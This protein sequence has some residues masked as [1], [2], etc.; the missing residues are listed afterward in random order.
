[1]DKNYLKYSLILM[2]QYCSINDF[3]VHQWN[4][5]E[6][7][8]EFIKY[9]PKN[10]DYYK[11]HRFIKISRGFYPQFK[12]GYLWGRYEDVEFYKRLGWIQNENGDW[13]EIEKAF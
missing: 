7:P 8:N 9:P 4:R 3:E 10:I 12:K 11:G 6:K 5:Q 13:E 2:G 1:M